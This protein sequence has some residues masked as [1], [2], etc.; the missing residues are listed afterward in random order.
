M[1]QTINPYLQTSVVDLERW[2]V[3]L[4]T[5]YEVGDDCLHP[6]TGEI[7]SDADYDAMRRALEQLNPKSDIFKDGSASAHVS[8]GTIKKVKHSPPMTS[9]EKASHEDLATKERMLFKFLD[10]CVQNG[11]VSVKKLPVYDLAEKDVPLV[12]LKTGKKT[13]KTRHYTERKFGGKVFT[14]PRGYFY[15]T[16]KLDGVA[17]ALYYEKGK[18][19]RAGLRPRDGINGEDITEQ[20]KYIAG[21]PTTLKEPVTCSIRGEIICKNSDFAKVQAELRAAGEQLRANPRNHAAGGI[22]QFK[23]PSKVKAMRL[24]FIG[25][26]V[27]G[28]ASST[29]QY[30]TE[31]ERAKYIR[32][33]LG[34]EFI[35]CSDFNFYM[36]DTLEE[37]VG[38]LDYE[39]DGCV[40]GVNDL[41][42]QE[43]LGRHGNKDTG[44]PK[45]KIAWKFKE[46][47]AQ[48]V[49][50]SIEWQTGR[51]GKIVPVAN[52][53]AVRL[54]G[55]NV[56]RATLHNYGFML[57]N[58]IDV[59]TTVIVLKAGKIIPKVV[60]VISGQ[61]K[62][63]PNY[64][65]VCPST[66][67]PTEVR[68]GGVKDGEEMW[69][70]YSTSTTGN[71]VANLEHFLATLGILGLGESKI[72]QLVD[73]GKVKTW[74]D[75][76]RLTV[77]DAEACGMSKRQAL[78]AVA[79]L[80]LVPSPD[81]TKDDAKLE[82]KIENARKELK[83]FP[84]S[85]VFAAL[86]VKSAGKSAGKALVEHF[87]G[88]DPLNAML[89]AT[90]E[91]LEVVEEIG[92]QTA[93]VIHDFFEKKK[94]DINDLAK[95]IV[96]ELPKTGKLTGKVFCF[97]GGFAEGKRHWEEQ[98]ENLGG[99]C[100]GSVGSKMNYLVAGDGSGSKSEKAKE[101]GIPIIDIDELKKML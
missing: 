84:L 54:A 4:D 62:G 42:D 100:S 80:H 11:P 6:D 68:K 93:Q 12:D 56:S 75:F 1:S 95:Y 99:K 28:L 64:P 20:V 16:Y 32:T 94:D 72:Q 61:C 39:V 14:Y 63:E 33:K 71:V 46:E 101:L 49:I 15:M 43:Q 22:R 17:C 45:G 91:E 34:V 7:V 85:K 31:I 58:K 86:G 59:G 13:D 78:L 90:V 38:E 23:D 70:L 29:A 88:P 52:F 24:S 89:S 37:F 73:G 10:F 21:I 19:I 60:R 69:E 40:I 44:N 48:A 25:H 79:A 65:K 47:E 96:L 3:A 8:D 66:G 30:K 50:K 2:I 18:L 87:K 57:R 27:E 98:V 36:L 35:R 83:S 26:S 92:T 67:A 76:F 82:E 9:I 5:A 51:T 53:D 41:E 81:K 77:A 74:A 55:T 97:S